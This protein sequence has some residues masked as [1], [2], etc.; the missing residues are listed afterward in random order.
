MQG[1]QPEFKEK[2]AKNQFEFPS[3]GHRPR[4]KNTPTSQ[5]KLPT[6]IRYIGRPV[7]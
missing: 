1:T 7:E 4:N 6:L 5:G 3:A 2:Q